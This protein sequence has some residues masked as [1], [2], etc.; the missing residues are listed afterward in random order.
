MYS[1][2]PADGERFFLRLLLTEVTGCKSYDCVGTL[3]NGSICEAF[4][5]AAAPRG[6]LY[7]DRERYI[8]F[9]E[10]SSHATP[11]ALSM[12]F[13]TI[14]AYCAPGSP[15][16]MW[17]TFA[18]HLAEDGSDEAIDKSLFQLNEDLRSVGS[19]LAVF[20]SLPQLSHERLKRQDG[21]QSSEFE[22]APQKVFADTHIPLINADQTL[23]FQSITSDVYSGTHGGAFHRWPRRVGGDF[24]VQRHD[25]SR[26]Q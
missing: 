18:Q 16:T 17:G 4:R 14:L 25:R 23:A 21:A 19:S 7:D 24:S 13:A 12:I 5:E 8:A 20:P 10:D 26:T 3:P 1:A 2:D 15:R 6:L 9:D 11:G 22:T